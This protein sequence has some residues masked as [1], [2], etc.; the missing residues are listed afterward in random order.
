MERVY[1]GKGKRVG[2]E[3]YLCL[4]KNRTDD[5][6]LEGKCAAT[7]EN[8]QTE[9]REPQ[10]KQRKN[11]LSERKPSGWKIDEVVGGGRLGEKLPN[12]GKSAAENRRTERK[13]ANRISLRKSASFHRMPTIRIVKDIQTG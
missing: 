6:A 3:R 9:Q 10:T 2:S 7:P 4:E 13:N 1:P 5:W 11:T 8:G 12:Q